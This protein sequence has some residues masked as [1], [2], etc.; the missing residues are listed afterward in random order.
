MCVYHSIEFSGTESSNE[1]RIQS[2]DTIFDR[3]SKLSVGVRKFIPLEIG[4]TLWTEKEKN[5]WIAQPYNFCLF[6]RANQKG[7]TFLV[8][9]DAIEFLL[10]NNFDF[11]K[12]IKE[13]ISFES[14]VENVSQDIPH[15]LD[16]LIQYTV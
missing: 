7:K 15:Q 3:Y 8:E 2:G 10:R 5:F 12:C 16:D 1:N 4:F 9:T 6:P 11:N 14:E 13:G